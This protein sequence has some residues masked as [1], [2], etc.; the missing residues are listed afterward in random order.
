MS[1][2]DKLVDK[3]LLDK[4]APSIYKCTNESETVSKLQETLIKILEEMNKSMMLNVVNKQIDELGSESNVK[5]KALKEKVKVFKQKI[6]DYT[7]RLDSVQ[8]RLIKLNKAIIDFS[9]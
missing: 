5:L 1:V 7:T 4:L 8:T 3:L 2:Q 6:A 9:N